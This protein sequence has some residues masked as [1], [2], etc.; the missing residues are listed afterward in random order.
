MRSETFTCQKAN[1]IDLVD[2]LESLGYA[3]VKK[4][5]QDYWYLSPLRD[6]RTA[7]FKVDRN[8]NIWFDFGAGIGGSLIDFAIRYHQCSVKELLYKLEQ[9][10]GMTFPVHQPSRT[11]QPITD[12]ITIKD[13]RAIANPVLKQYLQD[14]NITLSVAKRHCTEIEFEVN[15][16][17]QQAIGFKNDLGG[18]ELRNPEFKGSNSPK[19]VTHIKNNPDRL[20]VF[21]GFF[22]FLSF[23][24][25]NRASAPKN[26]FLATD[27][28]SFLI[29]NS[30]AFFERSRMLM[31]SYQN[32]DL[33]LDR[34]SAGQRT[35]QLALGWSSKFSD[36]SE[37][38]RAYKDLNDFLVRDQTAC[39]PSPERFE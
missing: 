8:K 10:Q 26:Y 9:E 22:D 6:E 25:Y 32:I 20:L 33:F 7:S 3:A 24:C 15:H 19:S 38:Y 17:K 30:L 39:H 31:E 4:S 35:T 11:D 37:L 18:Y 16:W 21:E 28:E 29:L 1:A 12:K 36:K 2:Y 23:L 27:G 34:D 5:N 13:I 14:R